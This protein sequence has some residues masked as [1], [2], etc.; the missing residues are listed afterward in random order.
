MAR[1]EATDSWNTFT[2]STDEILS[3]EEGIVVLSSD[4]SPADDDGTSWKAGEKAVLISGVTYSYRRA[5]GFPSYF[6]RMQFS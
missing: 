2:P 6:D 4:A 3:V 5:A 1:T